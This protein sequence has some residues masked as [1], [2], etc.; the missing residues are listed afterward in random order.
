MC[1]YFQITENF[2]TKEFNSPDEE[3]SGNR[4]NIMLVVYC[5]SIRDELGKKLVVSSGVR[6]LEHNASIGGAKDSSHLDGLAVDLL[7]HNFQDLHTI[8][9][10]ALKLG[11]TR[12]GIYSR[13]VHLDVDKNKPQNTIWYGSYKN[14]EICVC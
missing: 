6:T 9:S 5:Q 13:H 4:I 8:V 7:Y 3:F 2:N 12:I 1:T 10:T 11:I 14:K